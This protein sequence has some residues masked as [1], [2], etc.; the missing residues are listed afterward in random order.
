MHRS[1]AKL[2]DQVV[3]LTGASS[4]I[5]LVTAR[6]AAERGAHLVLCSRDDDALQQLAQEINDNG[7]T[8][9]AASADVA[10]QQALRAVADAA[11]K[12]FG[13]I[14]TWINNA[15]VSIYGRLEEVAP[16]DH[17]RLFETNFWGVVN[18][19]LLAAEFMRPR[20]G[21]I[22]NVGSVLSDLSIPMQGMYC[23]SKHAVKGF[24]DAFR[25]ELEEQG[26]PI[27]VCLIKPSA[28]DTPYTTHA[29]NYM[30]MKPQNPMPVYDPALVAHAILHCAV[31]PKREVVIG[32]G[33]R[34][35]TAAAHW[36]P[37]LTDLIME[38]LMVTGQQTDEPED[39]VFGSLHEPDENL[40]ERGEYDGRVHARSLYT[41]A[42]M[43]PLSTTAAA[44]AATAAAAAG[45]WL[46]REWLHSPRSRRGGSRRRSSANGAPAKHGAAASMTDSHNGRSRRHRAGTQR[47]AGRGAARRRG[48][49]RSPGARATNA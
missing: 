31:H 17:R 39:H 28:I 48:R 33:G 15:G 45:A 4:G 42:R 6:Q 11:I 46:T 44:L 26:T 27:A 38:R 1:G 20:G 12:E 35:M 3:V 49:A 18:G 19:S 37:R 43:H 30:R 25:M 2:E 21:V 23:A 14:D 9:V 41:T 29:R 22:I 10:D 36:L 40:Q 16:S 5:G 7:G 47:R 32:G 24:T 13:R 34:A 8:A